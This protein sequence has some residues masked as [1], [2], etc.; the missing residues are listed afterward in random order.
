MPIS[1]GS[2]LKNRGDNS[3]DY[4]LYR[5]HGRTMDKNGAEIKARYAKNLNKTTAAGTVINA[6][7]VLNK[8]TAAARSGCKFNVAA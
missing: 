3:N 2:V 8:T 5:V 1:S 7:K 6:N 4:G